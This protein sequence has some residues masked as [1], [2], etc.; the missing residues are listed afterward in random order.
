MSYLIY[1]WRQRMWCRCWTSSSPQG[2]E[3][4]SRKQKRFN[5]VH[6]YIFIK[7]FLLNYPGFRRRSRIRS[8]WLWPFFLGAGDGARIGEWDSFLIQ[9]HWIIYSLE[10]I[11]C[12]NVFKLFEQMLFLNYQNIFQMII[13]L[14]SINMYTY[15]CNIFFHRSYLIIFYV[16]I[17]KIARQE[18]LFL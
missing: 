18:N 8:R 5:K 11:K 16:N 2:R 15:V 13:I 9:T 12:M 7:M 14:H 10:V 4:P 3:S 17:L 1:L 6:D